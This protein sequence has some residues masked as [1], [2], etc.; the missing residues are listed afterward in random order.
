MEW[1]NVNEEMPD[2][3]RDILV[4]TSTGQRGNA[5]LLDGEFIQNGYGNVERYEYTDVLYWMPFPESPSL[6]AI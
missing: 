3:N 4:V 5:Y 6:S 1:K 2:D